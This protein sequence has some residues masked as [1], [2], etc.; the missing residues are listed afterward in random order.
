MWFTNALGNSIGRITTSGVLSSY[1]DSSIDDPVSIAVG[2]DGALW[3]TNVGNNSIGSIT[4]TGVVSNY[5][6]PSIDNPTSIVAGPDG[7][8][9]FINLGNT[10]GRITT[11]GV[12]SNFTDPSIDNPES[13]TAGPDGALW[14]TNSG[15]YNPHTGVWQGESI[16][17]ITTAGAVTSYTS[18]TI[19]HPDGITAGPDGALWFTNESTGNTS[20]TGSIGRITTSG[21]ISAYT[22]SSIGQPQAI[23]VGPDGALWYF[24]GGTRA[25][26]TATLGR[27]TTAGA[28]SNYSYLTSCNCGLQGLVSGPDG[29]LWF[30]TTFNTIGEI[31][32]PPYATV[33]PASGPPGTQV[34][35]AGAGF[36][37]GET[38]TATYKTGLTEP[39]DVT[40]CTAVATSSG[41]YSCTGDIPAAST[42]GS[43]GLHKIKAKGG[44]S[45]SVAKAGYSLT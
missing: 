41:S 22:N 2:S 11:A 39:K 44:T 27:I 32:T 16:S 40:V 18:S 24:N 37:P 1:S 25:T 35:V 14:F 7:A 4:T 29:Q 15:T 23:T 9:W 19:D 26:L 12:V 33:N 31:T 10:I 8:L 28:V 42:A 13:I 21:S 34:A 36:T 38:V 6:D 43:T 17:R 30:T 20:L 45:A 3:F 5:T